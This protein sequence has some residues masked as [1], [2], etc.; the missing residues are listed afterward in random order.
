MEILPWVPPVR[1]F[2]DAED[3]DNKDTGND[4]EDDS[5]GQYRFSVSLPVHEDP[6]SESELTRKGKVKRL[7]KKQ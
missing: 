5:S 6:P 7:T 4:R 3:Q 2:T 1:V